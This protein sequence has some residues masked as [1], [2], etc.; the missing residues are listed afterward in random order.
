MQTLA[1]AQ[2]EPLDTAGADL[3]H[4]C[5]VAL[6]G[7]SPGR[8]A[9]HTTDDLTG[10]IKKNDIEAEAHAER[11]NLPAGAEQQALIGF[12]RGA[13]QQTT[14]ARRKA[15]SV[16]HAAQ[17]QALLTVN[18]NPHPASIGAADPCCWRLCR[19]CG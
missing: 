4:V 10:L 8:Q 5:C 14:Q 18:T 1:D 11:M 3:Q 6:A 15:R 17:Q 7:H 12:E 16:A 9:R 13:E 2:T 19:L